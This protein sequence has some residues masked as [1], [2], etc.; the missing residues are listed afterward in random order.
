MDLMDIGLRIK[1][2]RKQ[3]RLTQEE[4]S[5][6]AGLSP[7]YIYEIERGSK[8]MSLP[9]LGKILDALDVSADYLLYGKEFPDKAGPPSDKLSLLIEELPPHRRDNLADILT[10]MLPHLK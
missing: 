6:I 8:T 4:F 7:H 10:V 2:C 3:K 1:Y 5:E 9:T